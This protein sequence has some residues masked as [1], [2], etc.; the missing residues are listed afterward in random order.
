M[1]TT[2]LYAALYSVMQE[3]NLLLLLLELILYRA[4]T[5]LMHSA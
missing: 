4:L 1:H 5:A 3:L 2:S